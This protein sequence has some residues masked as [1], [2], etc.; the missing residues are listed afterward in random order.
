M[1]IQEFNKT[2]K[3]VKRPPFSK[4][5]KENLSKSHIGNKKSKESIEKFK[6]TIK[7]NGGVW[8]KGRSN[9]YSEE[10]KKKISDYRKGKKESL[11]TRTKI[12]LSAKKGN[13]HWNWKGGINPINDTIRKSLE[14]K[15]W[16]E[17][18]FARDNYT[19][20]WCGQFGGK[21]NADHI[22]PF[23]DYP[24][25][26]FAIDNGRTLCEECHRKTDTWGCKLKKG[27]EPTI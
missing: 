19:C 5:W 14:Y 20:I 25:L 3:G 9:I 2:K 27:A 21:L 6:K 12:S 10:T 13:N 1:T 23:C 24:E 11:E 7:K 4:E 17:S 18:V 16:R 8:N 22:K 15:L 26:R